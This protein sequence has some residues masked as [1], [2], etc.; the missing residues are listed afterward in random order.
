[1]DWPHKVLLHQESHTGFWIGNNVIK[2]GNKVI[3]GRIENNTIIFLD[4]NS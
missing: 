2:D 4:G 1:M 3:K